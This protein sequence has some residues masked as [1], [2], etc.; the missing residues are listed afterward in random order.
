MLRPAGGS[1]G[2]G[3]PEPR[4]SWAFACRPAGR[5]SAAW[6]LG[7]L[8]GRSSACGL[9]RGP[10]RCARG[11][12]RF[13]GATR[14]PPGRPPGA[15]VGLAVPVP[16]RVSV[17]VPVRSS[18]GCTE[19]LR[20]PCRCRYASLFS[21]PY[22]G[23]LEAPPSIGRR[24]HP[25]AAGPDS[26]S[27]SLPKE[28]PGQR[29]RPVELPPPS[30]RLLLRQPPRRPQQPHARLGLLERPVGH[31]QEL[32]PPPAP[33]REPLNEVGHGADHR[34]PRLVCEVAH[35]PHRSSKGG[36]K[37]DRASLGGGD[38]EG[39]VTRRGRRGG[40]CAHRTPRRC[41]HEPPHR[42]RGSVRPRARASL[43]TGGRD[44]DGDADGNA[45]GYGHGHRHGYGHPC[46]CR[47][48][49]ACASQSPCRPPCA[50]LSPSP[51][52]FLCACG[53]P[54]LYRFPFPC[55][56]PCRAPCACASPFPCRAPCACASPDPYPC[57][58]PCAC[59]SPFPYRSPCACASPDP[60]PCRAPCAC[61]SPFPY[62]APCA[63][64]DPYP[65]RCP[66]ACASPS[67]YPPALEVTPNT[68]RRAGPGAAVRP[69]PARGS[70]RAPPRGPVLGR[71][72]G[73]A[74]LG[75]CRPTGGP[76]P[77][78]SGARHPRVFPVCRASGCAQGQPPG[79]PRARG[80]RDR[81]LQGSRAYRW[82]R[83]RTTRVFAPQ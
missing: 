50:S 79:R 72:G 51:C 35:A 54:A 76:P 15:A 29:P 44:A 20:C 16:V 65:C 73:G 1:G 78:A 14:R 40:S 22:T 10:T 3:A 69:G 7:G 41:A 55:R 39:G 80:R 45:D 62:R 11:P 53:S 21:S 19:P 81:R 56:A 17:F 64:P 31:F 46:R 49:C 5:S 57:R 2:T 60:Y 66:C 42:P 52:R 71:A 68:G 23:A 27:P 13:L 75:G 67:P 24:I 6:L 38:G 48:P 9:A 47:C 70:C 28:P 33:R 34:P 63:S 4:A 12:R 8:G 82:P 59:A 32:P 83:S 61:A 36:K 58:A 25:A 30:P 18:A 43:G 74:G 77:K 37:L 26:P